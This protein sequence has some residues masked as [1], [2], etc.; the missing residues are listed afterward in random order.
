MKVF[1][2]KSGSRDTYY[3]ATDLNNV[4]IAA[5]P[6]LG[7]PYH[8]NP[9]MRSI[10]NENN[11]VSLC[12]SGSLEP[13]NAEAVELVERHNKKQDVRGLKVSALLVLAMVALCV[14]SVIFSA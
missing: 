2:N 3:I 6:D 8:V 4:F 1:V 9:R 13:F 11:L 10:L 12:N 14:L 7:G 5:R